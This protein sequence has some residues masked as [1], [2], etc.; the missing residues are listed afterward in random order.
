MTSTELAARDTSQTVTLFGTDNPNAFVSAAS[1]HARALADVIKQRNL[2]VKVRNKAHVLVEGW[3]LLGSMVG[4]YPVLEATEHVEIN[5]VDGWKATVAATTRQGEVVGRATALCLRS[6]ARW[7]TAD[8]YAVCSMAQTRAVS[9]ALRQPLGFI[10]TLAGY[11]ATPA[12]EIPTVEATPV[13][14]EAPKAEKDSPFK[15]PAGAT[16]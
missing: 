3:T 7:K 10:I 6:E 2:Y 11:S 8:E 5:G 13:K 14:E 1:E 12:E 16:A 9:K 4:V 15:A